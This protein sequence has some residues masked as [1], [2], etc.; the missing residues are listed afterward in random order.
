MVLPVGDLK[1][2]LHAHGLYILKTSLD[3]HTR[4][5]AYMRTALENREICCQNKN[6]ST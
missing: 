3:A 1:G 4:Q 2:I 6:V 5:K